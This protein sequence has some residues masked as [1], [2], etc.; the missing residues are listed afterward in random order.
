MYWM[1]EVTRVLLGRGRLAEQP[2][3][4]ELGLFKSRWGEGGTVVWGGEVFFPVSL[5]CWSRDVLLSDPYLVR[6]REGG[7][8]DG[9][10]GRVGAGR[11]EGACWGCG[12]TGAASPS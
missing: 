4:G 8:M 11:K 5:V 10:M 9:A 6:L 3:S 12:V 7:L 2:M 1:G